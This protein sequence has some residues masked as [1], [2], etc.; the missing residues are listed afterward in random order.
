MTELWHR[1]FAETIEDLF[2]SVGVNPGIGVR[3]WRVELDLPLEVRFS[4][5]QNNLTLLAGL[6]VWC[7]RTVF[8]QVPSRVV[9]TWE[10]E[11][12]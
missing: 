2:E 9:M 6:P 3:P 10:E 11:R 1:P 4:G 7:W 12:R 8:D 5:E